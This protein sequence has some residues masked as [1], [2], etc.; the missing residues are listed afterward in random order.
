[1]PSESLE[2]RPSVRTRTPPD[3]KWLLNQRAALK[4]DVRFEAGR[5]TALER[6]FA[7]LSLRLQALSSE[8]AQANER[9][10]SVERNLWAVE[11]AIRLMYPGVNPDASGC[12][13]AWSGRFGERGA[14]T[15]CVR[16][17]L[18][19]VSPS[20]LPVADIQKNVIKRFGLVLKTIEDRDRLRWSVRTVLRNLRDLQ[21]VIEALDDHSGIQLR[22]LWR[23]KQ[24]ATLEQLRVT[25][26]GAT[27]EHAAHSDA[28]GAQVA[29][30]R[31]GDV[32]G[33][34]GED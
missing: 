30:Q 4:G 34:D 7:R 10:T 21:G 24:P 9:T 13:H 27:G 19:A 29:C 14:L 32:G 25:V 2:L 18:Q 1:M 6:Q 20:A 8:L 33:R 15:A 11:E 17:H 31:A 22:K 26:A 28:P 5:R 16:E 12:V 23:W 3:L